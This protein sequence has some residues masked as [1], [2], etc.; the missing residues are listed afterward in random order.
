MIHTTSSQVKRAPGTP[1]MLGKTLSALRIMSQWLRDSAGLQ[2]LKR[3]L[4]V[5]TSSNRTVWVASAQGAGFRES[6]TYMVCII[7][8]IYNLK[9]P[10]PCIGGSQLVQNEHFKLRRLPFC[11]LQSLLKACFLTQFMSLAFH[12]SFIMNHF[13]RAQASY[14]V[15]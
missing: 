6:Y 1:K 3:S 10:V 12:N 7:I 5:V 11:T 9:K 2:G 13:L 8:L 15:A 4:R 14:L